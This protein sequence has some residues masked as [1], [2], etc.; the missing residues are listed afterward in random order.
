[1]E[2][3]HEI[4][5]GI[6]DALNKNFDHKISAES[7]LISQ[8]RK[9]F[10]GDYTVVV[11]PYVKVLKSS[12]VEI[13][14]SL[15]DYVVKNHSSVNAFNVVKGF[16]NFSLSNEFWKNQLNEIAGNS[17]FGSHPKNGKKVMVEFSSPNTNKPLHLGHIRNILLGWSCSQIL[18]KAGYDVIKTQIINDRGIAVCKSML[19]WQKFGKG[20]TPESTGMKGD[21]FVGK[22]YVL[23]AEKIKE[24]YI[25]WQSTDQGQVVYNKLKKEG[26]SDEDFFAVYKNTYFNDFSILGNEAKDMLIA[27]EAKDD[28]V[29]N[30]WMM[31]NS[32]V[33]SGFKGTYKSLG[34]DFDK[35]YYESDTYLLGKKIV[36]K[37][38]TD[39]IF[40]TQDD[41][42]VWIDLDDAGMDK[43]LILRS[44]GTSV[45]I[46]QDIG[47]AQIRNKDFGVDKMVYVVGDEQDYHF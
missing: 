1:M 14:N 22:Y 30:L 38:L 9:E 40:Y 5:K 20:E 25:N 11:F 27:W 47:T 2:I 28:S 15:G 16:L 3:L 18:L 45:Y 8:T 7:V 4:Q 24:E 10:V 36:E 35:L 32:W 44:D 42:S 26:Q 6:V 46:T 12:P 34:V 13:G 43:K 41:G 37:G 33:Y 23:F 21:H 31:M 39:G 19:A 17:S 29:R